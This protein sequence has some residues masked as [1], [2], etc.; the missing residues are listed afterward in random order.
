MIGYNLKNENALKEAA[1]KYSV[2]LNLA[3]DLTLYKLIVSPD[4]FMV[5]G[6]YKDESGRPVKTIYL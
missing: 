5:A 3:G 2:D 6:Y 1:E 4:E